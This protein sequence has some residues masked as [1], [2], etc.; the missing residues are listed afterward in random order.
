MADDPILARLDQLGERLDQT[1]SDVV[2]R[3]DGLQAEI[4]LRFAD[5]R[6]Q[7]SAMNRT[8]GT[9]AA[10]LAQHLQDHGRGDAA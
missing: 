4:E 1:H 6:D 10:V 9:T 2:A 5:L 8:L 7:I 3:I